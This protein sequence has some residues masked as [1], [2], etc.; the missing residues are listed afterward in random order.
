MVTGAAGP[1]VKAARMNITQRVNS[2]HPCDLSYGTVDG[3]PLANLLVRMGFALD[4]PPDL[5]GMPVLHLEDHCWVID[6]H[7]DVLN[8]DRKFVSGYTVAWLK[9]I[10][11]GDADAKKAFVGTSAE[12][13]LNPN[14]A[15]YDVAHPELMP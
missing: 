13:E 11:E 5:Q 15:N 14:W 4:V 10:L 7:K 6:H 2:V 1:A 3:A 12:L 8:R 9:Y